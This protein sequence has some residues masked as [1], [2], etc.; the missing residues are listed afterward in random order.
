MLF[1]PDANILIYAK[2]SGM[3]EHKAA[4]KWLNT[5]LADTNTT[6]VAC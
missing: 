1:L 5:A 3:P 6:L 4:L 2:M